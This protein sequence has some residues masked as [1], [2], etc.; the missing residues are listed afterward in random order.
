M[1]DV[2]PAPDPLSLLHDALDRYESGAVA[3]LPPTSR[4]DE[5]LELLCGGREPR[6]GLGPAAA[7]QAA[8]P[9]ADQASE[10]LSSLAS[11]PLPPGALRFLPSPRSGDDLPVLSQPG[12]PP[13]AGYVGAYSPDERKKRLERFHEKRGRRVW[14]RK[15]KYDVRKN[16]ADTRMRVKGR[17]VKRED[18]DLL[19]DLSSTV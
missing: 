18:E 4:Q 10:L 6:F 5:A 19:R 1:A 15:V 7:D 16:F 11:A 8:A 3:S 17:F 9:G 12:A 14:T 13:R 2:R